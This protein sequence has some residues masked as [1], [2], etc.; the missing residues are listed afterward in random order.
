M[1]RSHCLFL[2]LPP[3]RSPPPFPLSLSPP[4][5]LMLIHTPNLLSHNA[6]PPRPQTN[7]ATPARHTNTLCYRSRSRHGAAKLFAGRS[8]KHHGPTSRHTTN[9]VGATQAQT[10]S[11]GAACIYMTPKKDPAPCA[12]VTCDEYNMQIRV[13]N[14]HP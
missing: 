9:H 3:S 14:D 2:S 5:C 4:L 13:S 12:H 7:G 6:P 11:H 1:Q 8:E 10:G